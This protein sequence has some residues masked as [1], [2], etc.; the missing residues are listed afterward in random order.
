MRAYMTCLRKNKMST[1]ACV[2]E[3]KAYL[4]CRMEKFVS[5]DVIMTDKK[6]RLTDGVVSKGSDV[7]TRVLDVGVWRQ[8]KTR[9]KSGGLG[10]KTVDRADRR[11]DTR[12]R[13]QEKLITITIVIFIFIIFIIVVIV[14]FVINFCS[15]SSFCFDHHTKDD[16]NNRIHPSLKG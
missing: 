9:H 2:E 4:K 8:H 3:S 11:H 13:P 7:R 6:E 12:Q 14:F 16:D 15:C 1:P 10:D 5:R